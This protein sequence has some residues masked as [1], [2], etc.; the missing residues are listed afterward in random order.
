[1]KGFFIMADRRRSLNPPTRPDEHIHVEIWKSD[2][3]EWAFR[4]TDYDPSKPRATR[5]LVREDAGYKSL[6]SVALFVAKAVAKYLA[7]G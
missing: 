5:T 4:I 3:C 2:R 1:L 6:L 7:G